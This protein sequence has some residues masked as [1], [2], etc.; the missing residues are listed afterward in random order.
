MAHRP[1]PHVLE[2]GTAALIAARRADVAAGAQA[3]TVCGC[4]DNYACVGG[5][6]WIHTPLVEVP[7]CSSCAG[8]PAQEV[9]DLRQL[10]EGLA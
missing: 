2:H 3:C 8:D 6:W 10:L 5:R 7:L 1:H 9:A 4:T